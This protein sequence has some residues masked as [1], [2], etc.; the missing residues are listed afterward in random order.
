MARVPR[1][2]TAL[3]A[4]LLAVVGGYVLIEAGASVAGAVLLFLGV[5][6][7]AAS[8]GILEVETEPS[9]DVE[10]PPW[11]AAAAGLG[12]ALAVTPFE[13]LPYPGNAPVPR[14]AGGLSVGLVVTAAAYV[15]LLALQAA[16]RRSR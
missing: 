10:W 16:M 13:V 7:L 3:L 15:L 6:L 5:G 14:A 12:A 2:L 8:W 9:G 4:G 1:W 11:I